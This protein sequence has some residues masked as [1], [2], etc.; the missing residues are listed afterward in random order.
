MLFSPMRIL[1]AFPWSALI[2]YATLRQRRVARPSPPSSFH[3]NPF[4]ENIRRMNRLFSSIQRTS[5]LRITAAL[6]PFLSSKITWFKRFVKDKMFP[7]NPRPGVSCQVSPFPHCC[8]Y[9]SDQ[10]VP[11]PKFDSPSFR[12]FEKISL[13]PWFILR[14]TLTDPP[15]LRNR[16]FPMLGV[17]KIEGL[18][19]PGI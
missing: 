14:G 19:S 1:W 8:W 6:S 5:F 15:H 9:Y 4:L 10:S 12:S 18:G 11:I 13:P 7:R 3:S 2:S 16:L 17:Q